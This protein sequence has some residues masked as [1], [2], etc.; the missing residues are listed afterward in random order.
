MPSSTDL[1]DL[2]P[3][4]RIEYPAGSYSKKTGGTQFTS[5]FTALEKESAEVNAGGY[6]RMLLAYDIWFPSGYK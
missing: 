5:N 4:L 3:V 6:Q 1:S 2:P